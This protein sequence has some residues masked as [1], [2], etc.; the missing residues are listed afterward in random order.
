MMAHS[1]NEDEEDLGELDHAPLI[2]QEHV[3]SSADD[4]SSEDFS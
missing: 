3:V 4:T 1:D 2:Q